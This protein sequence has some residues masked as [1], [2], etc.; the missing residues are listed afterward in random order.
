MLKPV[1]TIEQVDALTLDMIEAYNEVRRIL[2]LPEVGPKDFGGCV[3]FT[4][5]SVEIHHEVRLCFGL[6]VRLDIEHGGYRGSTASRIEVKW[7]SG[8]GTV[9]EALA[10][11]TLQMD[12][13][14]RVA[15]AEMVLSQ[16][17]RHAIRAGA[18]EAVF[19][20][21]GRRSKAAWDA[22]KAAKAVAP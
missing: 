9:S 15:Q 8:G 13:L 1:V 11:A 10:Q 12:Y 19:A 16:S 17:W 6:N 4:G 3:N 5:W 7:P 21:L 20:E 22:H 14:G 2:A 18:E